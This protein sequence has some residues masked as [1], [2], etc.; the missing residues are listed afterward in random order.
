MNNE[1][2]DHLLRDSVK[3]PV[4]GEDYWSHFPET[5][6]AR[7]QALPRGRAE[8]STFVPVPSGSS[9]L[10]QLSRLKL[11][12]A[13]TLILLLTSFKVGHR[14]GKETPPAIQNEE[15]H[16]ARAILKELSEFFPGQ[17][18]A[19]SLNGTS[20]ELVLSPAPNLPASTPVL[21]H[22][23]TNPNNS[24][25]RFITFSGRQIEVDGERYDVLLTAQGDVLVVGERGL[26]KFVGR[27]VEVVL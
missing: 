23:C 22:L 16:E 15:L 10:Q 11:P 20:T 18:I 7:I 5:V 8:T 9:L 24:C 14:F 19:V 12:L 2:L 4:R 27:P 21:I 13:A 1:E 6:R 26:P 17:L 3:P 25:R